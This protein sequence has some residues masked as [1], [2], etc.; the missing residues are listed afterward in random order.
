[1]S[2]YG[3]SLLLFAMWFGLLV[4]VFPFVLGDIIKNIIRRWRK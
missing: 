3:D 4:F 2:L 1:M